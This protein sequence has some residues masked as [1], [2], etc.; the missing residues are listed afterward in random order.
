MRILGA[1]G[2]VFGAQGQVV[3]IDGALALTER[4]LSG[5][6]LDRFGFRPLPTHHTPFPH[7]SIRAQAHSSPIHH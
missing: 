5:P 1:L 2:V 6:I 7:F 4:S 3:F